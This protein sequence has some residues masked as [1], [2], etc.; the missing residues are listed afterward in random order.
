M[1]GRLGQVLAWTAN[2]IAVALLV[3]GTVASFRQRVLC[4][5]GQG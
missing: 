3:I 5:L 2:T 4:L 1:A